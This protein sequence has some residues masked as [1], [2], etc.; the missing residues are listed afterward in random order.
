MKGVLTGWVALLAGTSAAVAGATAID[1]A[2]DPAAILRDV[3]AHGAA[4]VVRELYDH[5]ARWDGVLRHVELGEEA[6]LRVAIALRPGTDAGSASELHDSVVAALA[7]APANVLRVAVPEFP[8]SDLCG[9]RHDPLATYDAA[10]N[11][12][13]KMMAAVA[14]I[15]SAQLSKR[16]DECLSTLK[17]ARADLK[18][19]FARE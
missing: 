15:E 4:T 19:F 6:W 13:G 16:R 11:E 18:R 10:V 1:H 12:V 7:V 14:A 3:S 9:G 17:A 2:A 8:L 5:R